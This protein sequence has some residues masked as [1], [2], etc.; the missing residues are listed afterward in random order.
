MLPPRLTGAF[1][2][3]DGLLH[4][5]AL[6]LH[7]VDLD[8][9][10]RLRRRGEV[11][12]VRTGVYAT[13]EVWAATENDVAAREV[14]HARAAGMTMR[15]GRVFSHD[16]AA[17]LLGLPFLR[18][19]E[20]LVHTTEP[21]YTGGFRAARGIKHH[22]APYLPEQVRRTGH[23]PALDLAR[24]ACDLT[25][26]HGLRTG[27]GACDA[28][29]RRGVSRTQLVDAVAAM[30]SWRHVTVVREA[31]A[32]ADPGAENP[33]ESLARLAV[34]ELGLGTPTTQFP[35][36]LGGSIAWCDLLLGPQ[37]F[38]FDGRLKYRRA[39]EGGVATRDVGQVVWDERTRERHLLGK[40]LGVS[41]LTW[42]DLLPRQWAQ[43]RERLARE[44]AQTV[45]RVGPHTPPE[46]L[47]GAE[48]L[49][50]Q[51]DRRLRAA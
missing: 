15:P 29:L 26:E 2:A 16:S 47:T 14:L 10:R 12:R 25:R 20:P 38:E 44:L 4:V 22:G 51:R 9:V 30:R 36:D 39:E 49:R 40:G 46:L 13:E 18:P 45:A 1:A 50:T 35:V 24:T 23:G 32:L 41:R 19:A 17:H 6:A 27:I 37:V 34:H 7:G 31:I 48:A 33:A 42:D 11:V 21:R 3:N 5:E 8:E 43:T 28:A